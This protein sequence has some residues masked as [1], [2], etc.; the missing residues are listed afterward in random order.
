[1][2]GLTHIQ[3]ESRI[4]FEKSASKSAYIRQDGNKLLRDEPNCVDI[5]ADIYT[6]AI[7]AAP[8]DSKELAL[9]HAN[10][11]EMFLRLEGFEEVKL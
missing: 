10:R 11:A 6:K 5:I 4:K 3:F 9:A 2:E 1:M 7:F 8:P